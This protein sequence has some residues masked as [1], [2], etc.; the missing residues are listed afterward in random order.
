M[1]CLQPTNFYIYL[2]IIILFS[3][4]NYQII[5]RIVKILIF[6]KRL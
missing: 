3:K 4:V 6:S 1:I 2:T 5:G